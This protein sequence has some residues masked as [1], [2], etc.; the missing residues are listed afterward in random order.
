MKFC[1]LCGAE[2]STQDGENRCRACDDAG[3]TNRTEKRRRKATAA[4]KR[5]MEQALRDCGLVK[6]R[7]SLGGV[8]WE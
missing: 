3:D 2:I 6:V 4:G 1:E 7:G 5:E 8:Y